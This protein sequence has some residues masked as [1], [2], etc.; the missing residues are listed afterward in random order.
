MKSSN[1]QTRGQ[2]SAGFGYINHTTVDN[3][4]VGGLF[5][6]CWYPVIKI[7]SC[8]A[9]N[10]SSSSR[11]TKRLNPIPYEKDG[12]EVIIIEWKIYMGSYPFV[13]LIVK[14]RSNNNCS[15]YQAHPLLSSW[16]IITEGGEGQRIYV[17]GSLVVEAN[18]R[19]AIVLWRWS[20]LW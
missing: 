11:E 20:M 8:S 9:Y 1:R 10:G 13:T 19:E 4:M 3:R 5:V 17:Y 7:P 2:T 16:N 15:S 6:R 18:R 14:V 12:V